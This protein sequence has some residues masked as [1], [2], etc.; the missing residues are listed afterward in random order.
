M[1]NLTGIKGKALGKIAKKAEVQLMEQTKREQQMDRQPSDTDPLGMW[2]GVPE[3][4]FETPVQDA[5]DL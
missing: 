5:D 4:P 2:T 1:S 3:D